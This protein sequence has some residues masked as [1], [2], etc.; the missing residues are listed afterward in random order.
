MRLNLTFWKS[1]ILLKSLNDFINDILSFIHYMH[2][3][4]T[5]TFLMIK[6][7]FCEVKHKNW[8][9]VFNVYFQCHTLFTLLSKRQ[10][11]N[12]TNENTFRETH[13]PFFKTWAAC[14]QTQPLSYKYIIITT[15][16]LETAACLF[17]TFEHYFLARFARLYLIS[18]TEFQAA[19]SAL[20][21]ERDSA[22]R[23]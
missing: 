10:K 6:F 12:E 14:V 17:V 22:T 5:I 18:E 19:R 16:L 8:I 4:V 23:C 7:V 1:F 2:S 15:I 20:Q 13:R 9:N 21:N 3:K 11:Q